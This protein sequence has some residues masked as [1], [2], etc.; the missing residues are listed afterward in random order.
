MTGSSKRTRVKTDPARPVGYF[1]N[2]GPNKI[3]SV[4]HLPTFIG[5]SNTLEAE[6]PGIWGAS[7]HALT[8]GFI[9]AMVFSVGQRVL[10]STEQT[11]PALASGSTTP[12]FHKMMAGCLLRVAS[13]IVA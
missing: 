8:V 12:A 3:S 13:E 9:A 10:P 2:I 5:R 6:A 7:R 11:L 1:G 4:L